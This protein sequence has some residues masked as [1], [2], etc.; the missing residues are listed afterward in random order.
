MLEVS[1]NF[2]I[3]PMNL[4]SIP[5]ISVVMPVY[6]A[7]PFLNLSISSILGQT[8]GDFEFVI[9]DDASTDGSTELLQDW[10]R[11][12]ARIQLY[13]SDEQL[14]LAGSANAVVAKARAPIV[15]RMDADD[16]AHPDRLRLQLDVL[17]KELDVVA[18]GTLCTGIDAAGNE[19]RPRDR[20]RLLRTS[21]LIPF[22][23]GS[24]MFRRTAF[25]QIGGYNELMD[26]AEDQELFRN[27]TTV[28][29]VVTLANVLYSY[30]YHS[31]NATLLN[32]TRAVTQAERGHRSLS[33][34]Y[35]LGAMRLWR[36]SHRPCSNRC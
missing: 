7:L 15:A 32:G 30:R 10:A 35:M 36:V 9:L 8:F 34:F 17:T 3:T 19:V 28:G 33:A 29:R 21:P 20:W 2:V 31:S 4:T 26:G 18:V 5:Q 16:I 25:D 6:N 14:G 24:A 13:E 1:R 22:P 12:D 11:R 27:M 23:H